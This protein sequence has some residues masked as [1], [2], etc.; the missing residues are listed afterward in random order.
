MKIARAFFFLWSTAFASTAVAQLPGPNDNGATNVV[1]NPPLPGNYSVVERGQNHRVWAKS[2]AQSAPSGRIFYTTNTYTELETGM[3]HLKDGAW[4]ESTDDV[5]PSD[6]GAV[7]T[8]SAHKTTFAANAN[9]LEAIRLTMSDGETFSSHVLCLSY[10]EPSTGSNALIAELQNSIGQI[11][12]P[13]QVLYTNALSGDCSAD[14]LYRHTKAGLE[15]NIILR[16]QPPAPAEYGLQNAT[17]LEVWTEFVAAPSPAVL[18]TDANSSQNQSNTSPIMADQQLDFGVMKIGPGEAFLIGDPAIS[19][20]RVRVLKQ[21]VQIDNRT[22]LIEQVPLDSIAS[23]LQQLPESAAIMKGPGVGGN[24][25]R[26]ASTARRLPLPHFNN[27]TA[28]KIQVATLD[29]NSKRGFLLD[30]NMTSATNFTFQ[31]DTTYYVSGAIFLAGTNVFEGG[32]VIKYATNAAIEIWPTASTPT[33]SFLG[34]SYHPIICTAKDDDS[35]GEI[36]S[37]SSGTVSGFY[38]N[39]ALVFASLPQVVSLPYIR[40]SYAKQGIIFSGVSADISH[41]Q[42][43]SCSNALQIAGTSTH[44]RNVLFAKNL[45]NFVFVAGSLSSEN[46]TFSGIGCLALTS[47]SGGCGLVASNCIFAN[48]TNLTVG[49]VSLSGD[50]NGF[51]ISPTFGT[52]VTNSAY[53]FQSVGAAS[54]Y[55]TNGCSFL[56]AG[57]TNINSTLLAS[58][59]QKTTWPPLVFSNVTISADTN[60]GPAAARD[61]GGTPSLGYHYDPLDYA[62]GGVD[63]NANVTFTAGTAL[64]WFR[65]SS[66]WTHAGHGIHVGDTKT[67]TFNG[68]VNSP[69]YWVRCSVVQEGGTGKWNGGYGP[70]GITGWTWPNIAQAPVLQAHFTRFSVLASDS[71]HFRDDSGYLLVNAYSSEFSGGGLGGYVDAVQF[72]N[73]LLDRVNWWLEG[74]RPETALT[75]ENCTMHGGNLYINRWNDGVNGQTPVVIQDNSFDNTTFTTHDPYADNTNLTHCDYNAFQQSAPRLYPQGSHDVLV[76]NFNWQSIWLGNYYL[77][78]NSFLIN[79]GMVTADVVGL[80]HYTTQTNQTKEANTKVDIGYHYV[81][82]DA[83]GNP[84]DSDGDGVPDYLADKN[85]NGILDFGEIPFGITIENPVNGSILY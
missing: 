7:G 1:G 64:G 59:R 76:T 6:I 26:Y 13:N 44:L 52:I 31:A 2:I 60:F 20:P 30:Y 24:Q 45:T 43:L 48:I 58:L 80:F 10:F 25:R 70:G 19:R 36:I 61:T 63:A 34:T 83:N 79:T 14:I 50:T 3:H 68:L 51:Y 66:G 4:L 37:G 15:Q 53:P 38:A 73:C 65:T 29:V 12:L 55:L 11:L 32:C 5:T 8:N 57:T 46:N 21:W 40:V 56:T 17:M 33:A 41:S 18:S 54:Y 75:S 22:F 74:G 84:I 62:F 69:D 67:L 81:A 16:S 85:G 71:T 49:S 28:S 9:T 42:F 77:P 27:E 78:T 47:S 39:P 72:T 35:V 23:Q 82:V